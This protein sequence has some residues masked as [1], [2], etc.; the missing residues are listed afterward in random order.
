MSQRIIKF[1]GYSKRIQDWLYGDLVDYVSHIAI[2][3]IQ[4]SPKLLDTYMIIE[5][6]SIGQFTGL[7]DKNGAEIYEGDIL[8]CKC[9][10]LFK[11][12]GGV[13]EVGFANHEWKARYL[14]SSCPIKDALGFNW[15]GWESFEVIGNIYQ[16][17]KFLKQYES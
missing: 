12:H 6:A 10:S 7:L 14:I 8:D 15:G 9:T 13:S 5:R 2:F 1:R 11:N 16:T 3:P 4:L 17:P